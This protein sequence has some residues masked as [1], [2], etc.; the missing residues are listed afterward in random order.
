MEKRLGEF[1]STNFYLLS[2][3]LSPSSSDR[4]GGCRRREFLAIWFNNY[5][6]LALKWLS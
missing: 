1:S 5:S 4:F 6:H 3:S 2:L